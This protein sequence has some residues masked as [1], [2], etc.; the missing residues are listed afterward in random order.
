MFMPGA[1]LGEDPSTGEERAYGVENVEKA[2]W[3]LV[4]S[5]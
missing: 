2:R 5:P 1:Y 4:R 3:Q